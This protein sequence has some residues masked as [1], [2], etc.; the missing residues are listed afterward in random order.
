MHV[1]CSLQIYYRPLLSDFHIMNKRTIYSQI[2]Y[3]PQFE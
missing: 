3:I 2:I 1:T